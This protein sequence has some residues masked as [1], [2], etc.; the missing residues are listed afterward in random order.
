MAWGT[1]NLAYYY[2]IVLPEP[3][4]ITKLF[5]QNGTTVAGTVDL[6]WYTPEGGRI[7]STGPQTQ[8]GISATQVID[9]ADTALPPGPLYLGLLFSSATGTVFAV[10]GGPLFNA[11]IVGMYQQAVGSGTLP[12]PA[13]FAS[14]G[15]T[16]SPLPKAG[17]L[18]AP[19]TV[20]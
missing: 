9:I 3:C 6:G 8:A 4:V 14:V 18:V 1:A 12:N 5:W 13:V 11:M 7:V 16:N 19:R 2:P 10:A 17:A 20:L 15:N